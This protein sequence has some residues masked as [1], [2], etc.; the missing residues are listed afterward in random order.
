MYEEICITLNAYIKGSGGVPM[1]DITNKYDIRSFAEKVDVYATIDSGESGHATAFCTE[2]ITMFSNS[3]TTIS[4]VFG[5]G[6]EGEIKKIE[7]S[8]T[9]PEQG[10]TVYEYEYVLD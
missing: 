2:K 4:G 6:K 7:F 5:S 3:V 1:S 9:L 8:Y 10:K